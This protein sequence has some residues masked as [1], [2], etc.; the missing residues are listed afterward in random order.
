MVAI[1]TSVR[2][3]LIVVLICMS[4]IISDVEIF[5]MCLLAIH[6]SSLDKCLFR[7]S[8]HFPIGLF[9]FSVVGLYE[10]IVYFGV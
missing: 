6:M 7:S 10:L 1:L 5:F 2:C 3:Y 9:V 4:L 8:A